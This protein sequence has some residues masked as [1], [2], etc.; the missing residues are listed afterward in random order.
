MKLNTAMKPKIAH[1]EEHKSLQKREE[2]QSFLDLITFK[3]F[4]DAKTKKRLIRD[5]YS[6]QDEIETKLILI[7]RLKHE[8]ELIKEAYKERFKKS[9]FFIE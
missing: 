4:R 3:N 2:K 5:Y 6:K 8:Q 7:N 1:F 9:A